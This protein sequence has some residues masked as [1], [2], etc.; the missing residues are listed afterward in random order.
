MKRYWLPIYF[1]AVVYL[2]APS[3]FAHEQIY[4]FVL[5]GGTEIPANVSPGTGFARAT[6]DLDLLM[7]RVEASFSGLLGTTTAAHIH[8]CD[9]MP[10]GRAGVATQTPSFTGFPLGVTSGVMDQTFDMTLASSYRDVFL[11]ANGGSISSAFNSLL[12]GLDSGM[13]YFNIHSSSFPGG[14]IRGVADLVPEPTS[15]VLG[16]VGLSWLAVFRRRRK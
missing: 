1:A 6:V 15:V 8:C 2:A 3:A 14:E 16:V 7:M 13:A 4:E 10:D 9:F 11:T 12:A 5:S